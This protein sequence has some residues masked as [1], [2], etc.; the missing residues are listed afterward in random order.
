MCIR[1]RR[2]FQRLKGLGE[3]DYDELW[4]TTMDP[5]RRSLLKVSVEDTRAADTAFSELMGEDVEPRKRFIQTNAHDVR[6]L[7]I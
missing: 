3:M 4:E 5:V 1:D 7:D 2:E 6:F